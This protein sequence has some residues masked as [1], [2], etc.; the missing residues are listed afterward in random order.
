MRVAT[1]IS[2]LYFTPIIKLT[3]ILSNYVTESLL[4]QQIAYIGSINNQ[5]KIEVYQNALK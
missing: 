1:F 5:P 4:N 3:I 2:L